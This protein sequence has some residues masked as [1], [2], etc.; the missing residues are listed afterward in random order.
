MQQ[1]DSTQGQFEVGKLKDEPGKIG[2]LVDTNGKQI[3]SA[4]L[5][6]PPTTDP[7]ALYVVI[8]TDT[9]EQKQWKSMQNKEILRRIED[10]KNQK[11]LP[12]SALKFKPANDMILVLPSEAMKIS[13]ML[14]IPDTVQEKPNQGTIIRIS[15]KCSPEFLAEFN[16]TDKVIFG[17][18]AGLPIHFDGVEF[19]LMRELDVL[20]AFE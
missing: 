13:K 6:D 20:G 1:K 3:P 9:V 14:I 12:A 19:L 17:K 2:G 4:P 11:S 7:D 10:K 16:E 15:K 5:P 18:W 8:E